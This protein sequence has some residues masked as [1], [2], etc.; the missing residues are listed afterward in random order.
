MA[1]YIEVHRADGTKYTVPLTSFGGVTTTNH[2]ATV[3]VGDWAVGETI[4]SG[5][6]LDDVLVALGEPYISSSFSSFG[7]NFTGGAPTWEVGQAVSVTSGA[8]TVANDSLGFGIT[9]IA[10]TGTGFTGATVTTS[11]ASADAVNK[12]VNTASVGTITWNISGKNH[13][14]NTVSRNYSGSVMYRVGFGASAT[15]VSDNATAQSVYNGLGLKNLQATKALSTAGTTATNT[16]GNYFYIYIPV[17]YGTLASL[18]IG[19]FNSINAVVNLGQFS[20]TNAVGGVSNYYVYKSN[21]TGA[22]GVGTSVVIG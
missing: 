1:D 14:N 12:V 18:V 5:S 17:S 22:I 3:A 8:W 9:N 16:N 4:P 15:I 10:I 13:L 2:T 11:P 21:A 7:I 20:I 6:S 19:G